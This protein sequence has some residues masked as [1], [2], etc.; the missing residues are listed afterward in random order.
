M[1][2][3]MVGGGT[4]GH[5]YPAIAIAQAI[6]EKLMDS[7]ILFIGSE[8]GIETRLLPKERFSFVTIKVRGMLRKL[9]FRSISAPFLAV[10]GIFQAA[11]IIK[12]FKPD[13]IIATGGFVSLPVVIAGFFLRVPVV[14]HEGNLTPGLS[15]RICKW[16]AS[17]ITIAFEASRKHFR[18]RKVFCIGGPV[19]RDI[20]KTVK[21]IAMQNMGLRQ[22]QKVV[23]ILGGSQGARSINNVVVDSL[24]QL[25]EMNVQVL[26]VCGDRDH[27]MIK[28]KIRGYYPYYRLIP[29]MYNIWDGL[30]ASDLVVSRA[31]ATI[32]SEIIA[33]GLPSILI[34]FPFSAEGHQDLNAKLLADSGA[35]VIINDKDLTKE[36]LVSGIKKILSDRE[37]YQRMKSASSLLG[38]PDAANEAVNVVATLLGIDLNAKK[39]KKRIRK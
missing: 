25:L 9:S 10:S 34:P 23:L 4:G 1:K 39:R 21:G 19:R 38:R 27:D 22:D 12:T 37:L 13:A 35:S 24:D 2:V 36:T 31:G 14:L 18:F 5:I 16:F 3:I 17:R 28:E 6:Q 7:Q 30:A 32:I 11:G 26:H 29:Y 15:T 8:E 33:R 20:T